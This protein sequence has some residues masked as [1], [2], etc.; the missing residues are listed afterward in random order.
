[1]DLLTLTE[2]HTQTHDAHTRSHTHTH[3]HTHTR[4][5]THTHTHTH[6]LTH[7]HTHQHT[8]RHTH[9]HT[10]THTHPHTHT[11]GRVTKTENMSQ[12]Q[13]SYVVC[14]L[15][16]KSNPVSGLRKPRV[17]ESLRKSLSHFC[18]QTLDWCLAAAAFSHHWC[19]C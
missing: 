9:T 2:Y 17:L 18:I 6:S 7:T 8:H 4:T 19:V 1:M 10:H 14:T 12:T 5:H 16:D 15:D 13:H 11:F 3:T